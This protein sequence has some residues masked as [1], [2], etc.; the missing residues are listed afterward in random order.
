MNTK[1]HSFVSLEALAQTLG[2]PLTWL[3]AQADGG[4]IPCLIVSGRRV[5]DRDLVKQTLLKRMAPC[6]VARSR[7]YCR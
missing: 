3:K 5:F 7:S 2:L 6:C 4:Q 1:T